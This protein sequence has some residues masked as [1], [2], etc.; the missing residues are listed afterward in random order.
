MGRGRARLDLYWSN[1][2]SVASK[3][4]AKLVVPETEADLLKAIKSTGK[5]FG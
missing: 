1:L 4:E 3:I 2:P 5:Q